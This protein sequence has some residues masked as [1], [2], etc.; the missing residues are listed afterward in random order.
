MKFNK[1]D[2]VV[3]KGVS[4]DLHGIVEGVKT[5]WARPVV[6]NMDDSE[7][8]FTEDGREWDDEP[9]RLFHESDQTNEIAVSKNSWH[10]KFLCG[11][12]DTPPKSDFCGYFWQL[13]FWIALSTLIG[14]GGLV[15]LVALLFPFWQWFVDIDGDVVEVLVIVNFLFYG[16]IL[17]CILANWTV[18]GNYYFSTRTSNTPRKPSLMTSY[19]RAKK[20]KYCPIVQFVDK[21]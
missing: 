11:L 13:I 21:E 18:D 3:Y 1:G 17:A 2:K 16:G 15:L 19:W 8:A 10:Y 14:L 7:M 5:G 6:V 4:G 12:R 9:I 20:D